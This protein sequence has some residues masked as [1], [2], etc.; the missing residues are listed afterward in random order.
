MTEDQHDRALADAIRRARIRNGLTQAELADQLGIS[1]GLVASWESGRSSPSDDV[2][3]DMRDIL[4]RIRREYVRGRA[5]GKDGSAPAADSTTTRQPPAAVA[6]AETVAKA[7]VKRR[8]GRAT[9][10]AASEGAATSGPLTAQDLEARLWDAANS[11]R[12]PVDP[13]DFK[14]YI[15]PLL[16]F[17]RISDTWQWEHQRAL[18]DFDGNDELA[19]LPDNFRFQLPDG[20]RW[21]DL[22]QATQ[23]DNVG[24]ALQEMLDRIQQANPETLTGIFGDVPWGNKEKLPEHSLIGVI[25][26]FSRLKLDPESVPHD[27]LGNAYEYLLKQFADV[28][29]KKAGEFFTPRAVVRLLT[30]IVDPQAGESVYDPA[31]GSGGILVEAVNEVRES[32]GDVRTLRLYGQEVNLTTSAI[33][34]MNLFLHDI[35]DF[36]IVR[37]DT[38]RDPKFKANGQL[39][40]FDVVIANPP[41]SLSPWGYDSWRDDPWGRALCGLPPS[42]TGDFA[43]IQHMVSSMRPKTGRV[44]VVMPHG[45]LFRAGAERDI[46]RCLI[47]TGLLEA[48]IGLPPNLFYSTTIEACLLIFRNAIA[49]SRRGAVLFVDGSGEFVKGRKQNS[50]ADEHV[51]RILEAYQAGTHGGETPVPY[52][53]VP[54]EAIAANEWDLSLTKYMAGDRADAE[55]AAVVVARLNEALA[56]FHD[57]EQALAAR[58][59]AAGY[60]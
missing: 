46:R 38:L 4:G 27:I 51:E 36:K 6:A 29:G 22:V 18:A 5:E 34:R 35:E 16:F 7:P 23:L 58:L 53:V 3:A 59:K 52:A 40:K 24:V 19:L 31:C 39:A 13:S 25:N 50:L 14:A 30:R 55:S 21:Q 2:F 8:G 37:G 60:A 42:S 11:L 20:C 33:A 48:V 56:S 45:A 44:G 49:P 54:M 32:G 9:R 28:S 41:F 10:P 17:K 43:W 57:A 1:R 26:A 12:G 15:F 47:E